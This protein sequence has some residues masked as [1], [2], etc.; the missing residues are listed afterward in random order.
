[1]R[2]K[3]GSHEGSLPV[4]DVEPQTSGMRLMHFFSGP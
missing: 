1:M 3:F 2:A 4:G